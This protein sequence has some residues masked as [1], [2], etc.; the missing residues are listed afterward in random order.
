MWVFCSRT[1]KGNPL[2]NSILKRYQ[3]PRNGKRYS[4]SELVE[5]RDFGAQAK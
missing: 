3:A 2:R 1:M 5:L 4:K